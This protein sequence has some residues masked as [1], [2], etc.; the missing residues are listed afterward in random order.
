MWRVTVRS[1]ARSG[2]SII[3][4]PSRLSFAGSC[5]TRPGWTYCRP[6]PTRRGQWPYRRRRSR[7]VIAVTGGS[8]PQEGFDEG[9]WDGGLEAGL[10][11]RERQRDRRA[12]GVDGLPEG[13]AA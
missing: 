11:R 3:V 8:A 4:V 13:R 6:A 5:A 7:G 9:P 10:D 2:V 1:R 12:V